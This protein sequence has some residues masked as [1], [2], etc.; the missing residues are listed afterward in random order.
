[1]VRQVFRHAH[2]RLDTEQD[3][4]T[5]DQLSTNFADNGYRFRDLLVEL[6]AHSFAVVAI[7]PTGEDAR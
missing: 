4:V 3:D 2:A 6:V 5:L 7:A 1:M